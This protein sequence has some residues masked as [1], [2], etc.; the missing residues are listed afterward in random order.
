MVEND[1]NNENIW[2]SLSVYWS[3][4]NDGGQQAAATTVIESIQEYTGSLAM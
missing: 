2:G 1:D 4:N 3:D